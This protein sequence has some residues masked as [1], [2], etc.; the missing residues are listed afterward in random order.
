MPTTSLPLLTAGVVLA[1]LPVAH[2]APETPVL[3]A[4]MKRDDKGFI[5]PA[6]NAALQ[7]LLAQKPA[8][9]FIEA[10]GVGDAGEVARQ[11][12]AQP[13][14]ARSARAHGWTPL[15]F[16]A[17]SG[18]AQTLALLLA[19]SSLD[20]DVRATNR[21][22]NTPLMAAMLTGQHDTAKLLLERGADA[23][24]RQA[25][26]FSPMHEA[27]LLGRRDL[28]DLLLAHGAEV[29]VRAND[30]RTPLAEALRGGHQ[31]LAAFLRE[32]AAAD[33]SASKPRTLFLVRHAEKAAP[34]GDVPIS[35]AGRARAITLAGMLRDWKVEQVFTSQMLRT[36]Q[37][38]APVVERTRARV[39]AVPV[40]AVDALVAK[41]EGL[42]PGKVALVVNH[43]GKL[44]EIIAKLGGPRVDAIAEDEYDRLFVLTRGAGGST[45]VTLRYGASSP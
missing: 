40:E 43:S 27:A 23:L 44:P 37:T 39:E 21:F 12:R 28:V 34:N 10:C 5:P 19:P 7:A 2:A 9:S 32:K 1:I 25:G 8:L 35:A 4:L 6:R 36:Q 13:A 3:S 41:L 45:L 30:G 18:S 22:R 17:F 31:P 26:G 24:V 15:H 38:A 20:I 16:A 29:N 33:E 14:I 11:L 42:G